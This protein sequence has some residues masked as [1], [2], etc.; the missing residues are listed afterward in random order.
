MCQHESDEFG[1]VGITTVTGGVPEGNG[2]YLHTD[3]SVILTWENDVLINATACCA[4]IAAYYPDMNTGP[5]QFNET[6]W[7]PMIITYL[8]TWGTGELITIHGEMPEF[9]TGICQISLDS[10]TSY[11]TIGESFTQEEFAIG[12]TA[13]VTQL[14]FRWRILVTLANGCSYPSAQNTVFE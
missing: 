10:G 12:I 8:D 9:S 11:Y 5:F 3:S 4:G 1:F 13:P 7:V 14:S 6:T 2:S